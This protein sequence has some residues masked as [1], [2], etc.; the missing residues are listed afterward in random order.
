MWPLFR[1]S[2]LIITGQEHIYLHD[3]RERQFYSSAVTRSLVKSEVKIG[4]NVDGA[5]LSAPNVTTNKLMR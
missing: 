5:P 1:K 2:A 4:I 3:S